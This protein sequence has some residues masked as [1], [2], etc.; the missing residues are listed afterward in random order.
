MDRRCRRVVKG[1][2]ERFRFSLLLRRRRSIT[3]VAIS[4]MLWNA[5]NILRK[6][7]LYPY[8]GKSREKKQNMP[9]TSL[10]PLFLFAVD[11]ITVRAILAS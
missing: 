7:T 9:L 11:L 10:A 6:S 1:K 2:N 5:N 4:I 8:G 3:F